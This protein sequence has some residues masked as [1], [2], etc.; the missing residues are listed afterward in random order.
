MITYKNI[1][2]LADKLHDSYDAEEYFITCIGIV[3]SSIVF[4]PFFILLDIITAPIVIPIWIISKKMDK[5]KKYLKELVDKTIAKNKD[6][7]SDISFFPNEYPYD[8]FRTN[9]NIQQKYLDE[10]GQICR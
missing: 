7:M 5:R 1:K 10:I 4:F 3:I 9:V 2:Y 8:I 6:M